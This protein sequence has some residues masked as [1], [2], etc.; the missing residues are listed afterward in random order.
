MLVDI[1]KINFLITKKQRKK[2]LILSIL[3]FIGM[4]LEVLSLGLFIPVLSSILEPESLENLSSFS[5]FNE[6]YFESSYNQAI[7]PLKNNFRKI[8]LIFFLYLF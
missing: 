1:N 4:T 3:I 7:W 5:F 2:L 8:N 6:F